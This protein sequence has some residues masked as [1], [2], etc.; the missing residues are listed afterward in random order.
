MAG[1]EVSQN[2]ELELQQRLQKINT[3][4]EEIW[5]INES[6]DEMEVEWCLDWKFAEFLLK[7]ENASQYRM[8]KKDV[9][10]LR[11]WNWS[12]LWDKAWKGLEELAT[13]L[14]DIG[15]KERMKKDYDEFMK[16][17]TNKPNSLNIMKS[18]E[19]RR[20]NLYLWMSESGNVK[21]DALKAYNKMKEI[22][23][24]FEHYKMKSEDQRFFKSVWDNLASNYNSSDVFIENDYPAI[25]TLQPTVDS[26]KA[27]VGSDWDGSNNINIP[28]VNNSI[29]DKDKVKV[30]FEEKNNERIKNNEEK[31]GNIDILIDDLTKFTKK[32]GVLK[33]DWQ[34]FTVEK[35]MELFW[36]KIKELANQWTN[37]VSDGERNAMIDKS[38]NKIFD[39][40]KDGLLKNEWVKE[41]N[42][43]GDN[44]GNEKIND[45]TTYEFGK[46]DFRIKLNGL[47]DKIKELGFYDGNEEWDT[48]KFNISKV[49]EYL[50]NIQWE[51]WRKLQSQEPLKK[52]TWIIS[53]QIAL[54]YLWE[55]ENKSNY[56]VKFIDW[57]RKDKTIAWVR[58]FQEDNWLVW[59]NG[60]GDGK[61]WPKTIEKIIEKLWWSS[62]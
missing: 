36:D 61:P 2:S 5:G 42:T 15:D 56:N 62:N 27:F 40:L 29:V 38:K 25:K 39:K 52:A 43:E 49:K 50:I 34:E 11:N 46:T 44:G 51:S 24:S 37:F 17:I 55:K 48:I 9:D 45:G 19:I 32:D 18:R 1:V 23:G 31:M 21:S 54:N 35:M 3:E 28:D 13:F 7:P 53:V 26:L 57:I 41:E 4:I 33:Y 47:K 6:D 30:K 8:L 16:R 10:K 20:L 59:S 58:W 12:Q 22:N 14:D 60:K